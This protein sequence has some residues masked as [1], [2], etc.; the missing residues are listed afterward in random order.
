MTRSPFILVSALLLLAAS[1]MLGQE[2]GSHGYVR[3]LEGSAVLTRADTGERVDLL[4][5]YPLE[6]GDVLATDPATRIELVL[7]DFNLLRLDGDTRIGLAALAYSADS[8]DRATVL[9]LDGGELQ[10]EVTEYALGDNLPTV[11]TT[12]ATVYVLEPGSYRIGASPRGETRV[13]VRQGYAEVTTARG[14]AIARSDEEVLVAGVDW[15]AVT[16]SAASYPDDLELWADELARRAESAEYV[17]D[18]DPALGYSTAPLEEHGEWVS[19]EGERAWRPSVEV[20]WRPFTRGTWVHSRIG[21]TW[22]SY[23][24][25]GW[26]TTHYGH[27]SLHSSWGWVWYPGYV[28]SPA[29]VYWYWGPEWVGWVPAGYYGRPYYSPFYGYAGGSWAYYSHWTFCPT[30][31]VVHPHGH[32]HYHPGRE[33]ERRTGRPAVPRG[34]VTTHTGGIDRAVWRDGAQVA[35]VLERR[36][37]DTR[38]TRPPDVTDFVAGRAEP[39]R[40]AV[41][42][43]LVERGRSGWRDAVS[44]STVARRRDG[45]SS[46]ERRAPADRIAAQG[47]RDG[48]DDRAVSV[49][50]RSED[51]RGGH[52]ARD[53]RSGQLRPEGGR[54]DAASRLRQAWRSRYE[55]SDRYRIWQGHAGD[56]R[57]DRA[58]RSADPAG[59]RD[60]SRETL[61]PARRVIDGIRTRPETDRG[62]A[63]SSAP[64]DSGRTD[65]VTPPSRSSRDR[66]SSAAGRARSDGGRHSTSSKGRDA[67]SRDSG[68]SAR[69]RDS[70]GSARSRGSSSGRDGQARSSRS[71]GSDDGGSRSARGGS[72]RSPDHDG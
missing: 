62:G 4:P 55:S 66:G 1:P 26:V 15:P 68:D 3:T 46:S 6:A 29:W 69:G 8:D 63:A 52:A 60:W 56:G 47:W 70:G 39:P 17:D 13:V 10:L 59:E 43:D 45:G 64:R 14:S 21:L 50:P 23:E 49:R 33:M 11:H 9:E 42:R 20:S 41:G 27:W 12:N 57:H 72:R 38:G 24:P 61:P 40:D 51:V 44:D 35:E 54:D 7:P 67:R 28:Y 36:A 37:R 2:E 5:N 18:V 31:Y 71:R 53:D 30:V 22:V 48:A 34:V 19:V 58:G 65:R 25:W 32:R 16:L